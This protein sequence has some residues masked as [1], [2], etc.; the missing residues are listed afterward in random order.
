MII[1]LRFC[2][3]NLKNLI[4]SMEEIDDITIANSGRLGLFYLMTGT[5]TTVN[6]Q[7]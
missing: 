4:R 3:M 5:Y 7:R 6:P 1:S 2:T